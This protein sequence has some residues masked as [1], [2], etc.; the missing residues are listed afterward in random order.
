[1]RALLFV[2]INEYLYK[3]TNKNCMNAKGILIPSVIF[4]ILSV[5]NLFVKGHLE[6]SCYFPS[7]L[8]RFMNT[9]FENLFF[10]STSNDSFDSNTKLDANGTMVLEEME[11]RK[12]TVIN[13]GLET[14]SSLSY[15]GFNH[16]ISILIM[17]E[18][19]SF[20]A[21]PK[22]SLTNFYLPFQSFWGINTG[23]RHDFAQLQKLKTF[24]N[25]DYQNMLIRTA[26]ISGVKRKFNTIHE[27][28]FSYGIQY[29]IF[30][31]IS[32][33]N[34]IGFGRYFEFYNDLTQ[35][36]RLIFKGY[37]GLLKLFVQYEF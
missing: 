35:N 21:G 19:N 36:R 16:N 1:M 29:Q 11:V 7:P 3:S 31:K 28:N 24:F 32:V 26:R 22:I 34:S 17:S 4:F 37:N 20:Y 33:G 13:V 2:S 18:K 6:H 9:S 15:S 25:I 23:I 12:D 10:K 14:G 5:N 8:S 30:K 27:I